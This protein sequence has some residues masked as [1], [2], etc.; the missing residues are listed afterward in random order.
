[1][2]KKINL[3]CIILLSSS[4]LFGKEISKN[5]EYTIKFGFI[6]NKG[7]VENQEGT[8][9]QEVLYL[10]Q[11]NNLHVQLRKNGFSYELIQA[12]NMGS[13]VAKGQLENNE[14]PETNFKMHRVDIDFKGGNSNIE[15][16]EL[17]KGSGEIQYRAKES[18]S[19][20]LTCKSF[21]KI[22][23]KNVYPQT[24]IEFLI[25]EENG[26]QSFKYNIILHPGADANLVQFSIFGSNQTQITD[27]GNLAFET[28]CGSMEEQIP[29]SY[30]LQK[31]GAK[32]KAI[33]AKF[34][35]LDPNTIGFGL[36]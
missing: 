7:Q 3:L 22:L 25:S 16:Q 17:E 21:T 23:Y 26:R 13:T 20:Y 30:E 18:A 11:G 6:E 35:Q 1:M 9:N 28:S 32:G 4:I 24:D 27:K 34:I 5:N 36:N 33:E 10:F 8:I 19:S 31:N 12:Q 14:L 2:Y 29:M 15:I